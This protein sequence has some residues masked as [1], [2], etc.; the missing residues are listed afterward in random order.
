METHI[1]NVYMF[2]FHVKS[3]RYSF[4]FKKNVEIR[5]K[6]KRNNITLAKVQWLKLNKQT[7]YAITYV[8]ENS[9]ISYAL[10]KF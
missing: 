2:E 7:K 8:H 5:Y 6:M 10:Q 1:W 9:S 3:N 4:A